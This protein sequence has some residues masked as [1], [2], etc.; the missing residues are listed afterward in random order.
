[1]GKDKLTALFVARSQ[2]PGYHSDGAGLYLSVSQS[3]SKSWVYR[4]KAA[5]RP[6]EMG[7]GSF[8][9]TSLAEARA[10]AQ[11][12]RK[13]RADGNDPIEG[14]RQKLAAAAFE[15]STKEEVAYIGAKLLSINEIVRIQ[16]KIISGIYFLFDGNVLNYIGQSANVYIRIER[17]RNSSIKFD[18]WRFIPAAIKDLDYLEAAYIRAHKP[19]FNV[20]FRRRKSKPR[21]PAKQVAV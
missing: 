21:L 2:K 19:P 9:T 6:H 18:H 12:C 16:P 5:G 20:G 7:L 4:Y 13:M 15:N 14:K 10:K 1:M 11:E 17:H 8:R 3:G